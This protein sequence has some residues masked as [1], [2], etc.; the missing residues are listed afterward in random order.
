MS[1][2]AEIGFDDGKNEK[3]EVQIDRIKDMGDIERIGKRIRNNEILFIDVKPLKLLNAIDFNT[4]VTNLKRR[5]EDAHA[6]IYF[7]D[8]NWILIVP[9]TAELIR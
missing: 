2:Y 3:I 1:E 6:R 9:E 4:G 5:C 8:E 7:A